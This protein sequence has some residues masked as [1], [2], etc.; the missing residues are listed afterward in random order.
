MPTRGD[1]PPCGAWITFPD[2]EYPVLVPDGAYWAQLAS[3]IGVPEA[4]RLRA[5]PAAPRSFDPGRRGNLTAF[6]G[7][8]DS[9]VT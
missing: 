7:G 1:R 9:I 3:T 2:Q 5:P 6:S 8:D 4:E